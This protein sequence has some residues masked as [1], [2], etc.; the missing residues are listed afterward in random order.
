MTAGLFLGAL[1]LVLAGFVRPRAAEPPVAEG[2][3]KPSALAVV[4]LCAMLATLFVVQLRAVEIAAATQVPFP[5]A[6]ATLPVVPI[7]ES[8]PLYSHT[9]PW[10]ANAML[11][12]GVLETI[13]L[14][15]LYRALR[16]RR[17]RA[18]SCSPSA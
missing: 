14:Y 16:G 1:A 12:F 7:D 17:R 10:V 15:G 4:L 11:A 3:A 18:P 9:P 2:S 5:P 13:A 6:Y 8:P